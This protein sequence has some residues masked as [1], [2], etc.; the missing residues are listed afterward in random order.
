MVEENFNVNE[1]ALEQPSDAVY[2]LMMLLRVLG[3]HV[4][5]FKFGPIREYFYIWWVQSLTQD[6]DDYTIDISDMLIYK[7]AKNLLEI[8]K[9]DL[10]RRKPCWHRDLNLRPSDPQFTLSTCLPT[11]YRP[12]S[13]HVGSGNANICEEFSILIIKI[14]ES[15]PALNQPGLWFDDWATT[16]M[17]ENWTCSMFFGLFLPLWNFYHNYL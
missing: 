13:N 7:E 1:N 5:F 14:S 9:Y 4:K 17:N 3:S 8:F 16:D 6:T 12:P 10:L 2:C 15:N 11:A